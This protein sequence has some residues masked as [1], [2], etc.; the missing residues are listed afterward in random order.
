[1]LSFE[2]CWEIL[3]VYLGEQNKTEDYKVGLTG[4]HDEGEYCFAFGV[5]SKK[6][7]ET[8]DFNFFSVGEGPTLVDRRSGKIIPMA[9][10]GTMENYEKRGS[11]Y[12][13]LSNVLSV[14]G[15]YDDGLRESTFLLFRKV[16]NK[17]ILECKD[18]IDSLV[19]GKAFLFDT[20]VGREADIERFISDFENVG[21]TVRRLSVFETRAES[22][23]SVYPIEEP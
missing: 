12:N 6:F 4:W 3:Q 15:S 17:S 20:K 13:G 2:E 8:G 14:S 10:N 21:F 1:M 18:C 16:T 9:N 19:A 22:Q 7:I 11:P 23:G 5:N